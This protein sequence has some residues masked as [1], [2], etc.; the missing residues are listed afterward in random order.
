METI[1]GLVTANYTSSDPGKIA[2]SRPVAS[3]PYLG[4]YRV[5]D[6]AL[7]NLVNAGIETVGLIMPVNYRS[8]IDH[9]GSG[10]DWG[11]NRKN[12]GLFIMPGTAFGSSRLGQRFLLRDL[13]SDLVLLTRSNAKYVVASSSSFVFN[14]DVRALIDAHSASRAN[15]TMLTAPARRDDEDVMRLELEGNR[16]KSV[17]LGVQKGDHAFLDLFVIDREYLLDIL[18]RYS[19][20]DHLGLFEALAGDWN[21]MGVEAVQFDGYYAAI[22]NERSLYE[23]SVE[24][25]SPEVTSQLFPPERPVMTKTHDTAPAKYEAG[26]E[27]KNSIVSAGCHIYG[28]VKGS[29]LGRNVIVEPGAK[30][31]NSIIMQGSVVKEGASVRYA[32]VDRNN[33]IPAGHKIHGTPE[34]ALVIEKPRVKRS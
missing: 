16:V 3:I 26:S 2:R 5:L 10:K 6:F 34:D 12:G 9:V 7:S 27:V 11:L 28:S 25:L 18:E 19:D 29:I 22:F 8:I 21:A 20:I 15:I 30:V 14:A 1:L 13:T 32:I 31:R 33:V 4:R 24:G 23:A 17:T